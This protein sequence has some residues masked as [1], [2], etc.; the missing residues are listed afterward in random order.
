MSKVYNSHTR[1]TNTNYF[2]RVDRDGNPRLT[3]CSPPGGY[4]TV[5]GAKKAEIKEI[6]DQIHFCLET[7]TG[8]F[9]DIGEAKEQQGRVRLYCEINGFMNDIE[10]AKKREEKIKRLK[11]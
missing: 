10:E 7:I 4:S 9:N 2:V 6:Q 1:T 3:R 11:L 8:L 5:T